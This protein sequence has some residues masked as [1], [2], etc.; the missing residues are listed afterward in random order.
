VVAA[1]AP[2]ALRAGL[3]ETEGSAFDGWF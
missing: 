1:Q 3:N 2:E